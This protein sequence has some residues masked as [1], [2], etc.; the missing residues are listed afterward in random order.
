MRR[1]V[2]CNGCEMRHVGCHA[3]CKEYKEFEKRMTVMREE[4]SERRRSTPDWPR[5]VV[6]Y[7]WRELRW[8][9]R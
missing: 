9:R 1:N 6:K 7:I 2:P 5:G 4:Q 3:L 8:S